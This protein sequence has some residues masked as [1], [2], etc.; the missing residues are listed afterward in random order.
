MTIE[1]DNSAPLNGKPERLSVAGRLAS[2]VHRYLPVW[3]T[4]HV[5]IHQVA[6]LR[7]ELADAKADLA[8]SQHQLAGLR[9]QNL[10]TNL[11]LDETCLRLDQAHL[12]I[13]EQ[14][15][16]VDQ[17]SHRIDSLHEGIERANAQI[18]ASQERV[19]LLQEDLESESAQISEIDRGLKEARLRAGQTDADLGRL[20]EWYQDLQELHRG[21]PEKVLEVQKSYLPHFNDHA[22]L[23]AAGP[24]I[25][26]GCGRG[27]WL[28]LLNSEGWTVKGVDSSEQAVRESRER[29]LDVELGDLIDFIEACPDSA[30]AG[31]TAFQVIEHLPF[32]RI[33]ALMHA[34]YRALVPGGILLLETPNPEN[35]QVSSYSFWMDP[36]H[37]HP[38]PPPLIMDLSYHVGF[39]DGSVLRKNPWPQWREQEAEAGLESEVA[40][41][42]YGPQDYAILVYKPASDAQ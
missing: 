34:A 19:D 32:G 23:R 41:R 12:Q 33:T 36:T 27:E 15:E 35:L 22:W 6:G 4:V 31:V 39:R 29:G 24:I 16:R 30:L 3:R 40:Y 13:L 2:F 37:K 38:I 25:D 17:T 20:G 5:L 1:A 26:L 18:S 28:S 7:A 10:Q 21:A 8:H 9:E 14:G 42:L 11:R